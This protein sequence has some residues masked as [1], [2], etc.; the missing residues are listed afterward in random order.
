MTRPR[1]FW[2]CAGIIVAAT[3]TSAVVVGLSPITAITHIYF[4]TMGTGMGLWTHWLF[5][6]WV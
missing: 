2:L 6:G 5:R 3:G 1:A 4:A